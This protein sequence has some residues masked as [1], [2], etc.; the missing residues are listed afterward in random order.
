M[1]AADSSN[2]RAELDDDYDSD[3]YVFLT[4][5]SPW[6]NSKEL[7]ARALGLDQF[8]FWTKTKIEPNPNDVIYSYLEF[9]MLF[10]NKCNLYVLVKLWSIRRLDYIS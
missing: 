3:K 4:Q 6:F 5:L 10:I 1:W 2:Q 7:S 8:F 9:I